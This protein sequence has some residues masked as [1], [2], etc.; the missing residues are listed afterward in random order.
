MKLDV[1][2]TYATTAQG[3]MIH[4]DVL[5]PTG[6]NRDKALAYANDFLNEIGESTNAVKVA[7][8]NYCHTAM[9]NPYVQ[10][11]VETDGYFILRMEGFSS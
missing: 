6:E 5:L 10:K 3:S 2:D 8:C 1:Y 7:H 9:A 11:Q 4:F